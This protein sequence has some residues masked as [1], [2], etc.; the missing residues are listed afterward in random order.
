MVLQKSESMHTRPESA[1]YLTIVVPCFNEE[2]SVERSISTLLQAARTEFGEAFEVVLVDDG[3]TD[4][5]WEI[6]R[7]LSM[8]A[9]EVRL[10]HHGSNRGKGAALRTG[11]EHSMGRIIC[12][13]DCGLDLSPD[14]VSQLVESLKTGPCKAVIGSKSHPGSA[15]KYPWRRQS[16]SLAYRFLVRFLF[17]LPV[18]DTQ[19]GIKAFHREILEQALRFCSVERY[20]FDVELLVLV[21]KLGYTV[22][23]MPIQADYAKELK[24][25]VDS[26]EILRMF[27]DTIRVFYRLELVRAHDFKGIRTKV[28]PV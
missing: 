6:A 22:R 19:T 11:F 2:R 3:S 25:G 17:Q 1:P 27:L 18:G 21:R 13:L 9:L 4:H 24:S 10:L 7:A 12:F 23:E 8:Q 16:L 5:T 26:R 14:H 28:V 20:A 15:V